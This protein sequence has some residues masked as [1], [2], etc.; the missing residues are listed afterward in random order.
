MRRSALALVLALLLPPLAAAAPTPLTFDA[1]M[2]AAVEAATGVRTAR[3][4]LATVERDL[5]RV[6]ADPTSLRVARL[7][8]EHA[9]AR[10]VTAI[11][12]A[13]ASAMDAAARAFTDALESE[14]RLAVAEGALAIAATAREAA[15]IQF[16]AGAATRIDVER[17]ENDLRSAERDLDDARSARALAYDRLASLLGLPS[18]DLALAPPSEPQGV[19]DLE[20][21]LTELDRN[22]QL[23]AAAQ[24]VELAEAQLAAIDNPIASA[25]SDVAAA[26]DRLEAARLQV[27][28]QRRSL[29]LLV[30]QAHNGAASAEARWR[31]AEATAATA[32]EDVAVQRLRFEAGSISALALARAELQSQQQTAQLTAA[33]HALA[34]ALRQVDL[35]VLGAR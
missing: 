17:S 12:G 26:R 33:R 2:A 21:Y 11:A 31:S 13:S 16:E 9:V 18:G 27:D 24:Q 10:A 29:A 1:A 20:R 22:A 14:D 25:P 4:E 34:A 8:A 7:S 23:Q 35:T 15:G 6:A 28:E 32:R 19:P 5:A 30:R 3:L